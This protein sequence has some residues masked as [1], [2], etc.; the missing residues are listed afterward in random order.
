MFKSLNP[1]ALGITGRQ[2]EIIEL[3]L[4]YGFRG[5]E[6]DVNDFAKRVEHR[7]LDHAARFLRSAQ[8]KIGSFELPVR[9][10]G[11]ESV[12]GA[13]LEKLDQIISHAEAIGAKNCHTHVLPGSNTLP[14]HENF[15]MHRKRLGAIANVLAKRGIRL[16]L[17]L[18]VAPV[19]RQEQ[20]F[21]FIRE[22]EA[23]LTLL[24]SIGADNVGLMLDTWNWHFGGG[25]RDMLRNLG[26]KGIVSMYL[27]EA[28]ADAALEKL[29]EDQR[30]LA[31]ET[32]PVDNVGLLGLVHEM[33]YRGP[34]TLA[35]HPRCVSGKTRDAI[36]Q[37][38]GNVLDEL[39]RAIGL[40]RTPKLSTT[41]AAAAENAG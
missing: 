18:L 40:G 3:A 41:A 32:G 36:V 26:V 28:P 2:S 13:D 1:K 5:L 27:A 21:Q 20:Q 39:W 17:G 22:A 33:G 12:Y 11:D 6:L 37:H 34:V 14:Y 24:K 4:T 35:P 30:L 16:G 38:C 8:M 15:E 7:G 9:W 23:L 29:S 19:H 31:N 25:T 10:R